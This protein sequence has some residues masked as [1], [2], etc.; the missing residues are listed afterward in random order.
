MGK[1]QGRQQ[2]QHSI[3]KQG[4]PGKRT[5]AE[6]LASNRDANSSRY[7]V[8]AT[9]EKPEKVGTFQNQEDQRGVYRKNTYG[10][11]LTINIQS[12][13]TIFVSVDCVT[14]LSNKMVVGS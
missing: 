9:A 5:T 8:P 12:V 1:R 10:L 11:C 13:L 2:Q 7:Q 3:G 14:K 4:T 6:M